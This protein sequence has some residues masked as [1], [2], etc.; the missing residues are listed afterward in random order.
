[1][2]SAAARA[3]GRP[4]WMR[5]GGLS[6]RNLRAAIVVVGVRPRRVLGGDHRR[7]G[8][9][10]QPQHHRGGHELDQAERYEQRQQR[11]AFD[12]TTVSCQ[13]KRRSLRS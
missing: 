2:R 10:R 13:R 6:G 9:K 5:W 4:S 8:A 7:V 11:H 12:A 3:R 1:M